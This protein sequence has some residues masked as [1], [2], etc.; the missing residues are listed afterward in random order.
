MTRVRLQ[1]YYTCRLTI[2]KNTGLIVILFCVLR[3]SYAQSDTTGG[4]SVN[5]LAEVVVTA[6]RTVR[7]QDSL[8]VAV[9]IISK[10]AIQSM[11]SRRLIDVLREQTG[12]II[13]TDEHGSGLQ[14]QGLDPDYTMILIDGQPL[15]GRLTGKLDL[16]RVTVGNIERI[17]IIKGASS[18]LYG[19]EAIAGVVNIITS[20]PSAV[21]HG[22]VL[23]RGGSY[24]MADLTTSGDYVLANRKG[25]LQWLGNYYRTD[26]YK[27]PGQSTAVLPP[28]YSTTLQGR[29]NYRFSPRSSLVLSGRWAYRY[30]HTVY[31]LNGD[32]PQ[33][34]ATG[35][36]DVNLTGSWRYAF[37]SKWKSRLDYYV[38]LYNTDEKINKADTS[39]FRQALHRLEWQH[40]YTMS[41]ELLFT[42]GAGGNLESVVATRYP[43]RQTMQSGFL[44]LQQQ[45]NPKGWNITGGLRGDWHSVYGA[46]LSPKLAAQY[47]VNRKLSLKA[48]VGRGFKA[49]DFRQLY[50]TF[51]NPLVGYTVLGT[52]EV[53]KGAL[54]ALQESGQISMVYPTFYKAA[55][56]LK[57]ERSWSYNAGAV[58]K[59]MAVLRLEW[60]FFY[61]S[62]Q[63]LIQSVPIAEKT[64][65]WFVYSYEN[66]SK[67]YTKGMEFSGRWRVGGGLEVQAGYQLLYAKDRDILDSI[68][69]GTGNYAQI[70]NPQTGVVRPSEASD[71]FGLIQRSRHQANIRLLY[72][73]PDWGMTASA[74]LNYLSRAGFNDLNGNGFIDRYDQYVPAYGI[75]SFSLEKDVWKKRLSVQAGV[76]NVAGYTNALLAGQ[77]GRQVTGGIRYNFK[78]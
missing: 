29:L 37:S 39:F 28:Y 5:P 8:P 40:D 76:D 61:N 67:V 42:A 49:P 48:S 52:E 38:S 23:V 56:D 7:Q 18:S 65:G 12:M 31:D 35:E 55:A 58:Y 10:Q 2:M 54:E 9:T 25:D 22:E 30:Q 68:K 15:I 75:V 57:A 14:L 72:L 53:K 33:K 13:A 1:H 11:Q 50:L 73:L 66:V 34:D 21:T 20:A 43:G 3:V 59:P 62:V 78:K 32:G 36:N 77:P 64:N 69:A 16:S 27:L 45:Y 24:G 26:G 44:Y 60:N 41:R 17:E 6:S 70:R 51:T 47:H 4:A 74:R 19:S 71:Y 46:Q 63:N